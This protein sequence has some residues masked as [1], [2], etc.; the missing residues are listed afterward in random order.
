MK[1]FIDYFFKLFGI[2]GL[3]LGLS[4][5]GEPNQNPNEAPQAITVSVAP[6]LKKKITEWDE[7]TGRFQAVERVEV[8]ARVSGYISQ[9]NFEDGQV[10]QQGQTLY[11]IDPRPFQLSLERAKAELKR[12]LASKA[13]AESNFERV[14]ALK[15]SRAI[16]QEEYDQREQAL[17]A[18]NA[19]VQAA[20]AGVQSAELALSFTRVTAPITGRVS[21][22]LVNA[23]N[24]IRGG[25][26][27]GTL[28]TTIVSLDPIYFYFEGSEA[29]LLRYSRLDLRGER[30][31]SR[32]APNPVLVKLL[33]EK[34]YIHKG[35]MDFVDNELDAGTGTIEGRAVF[36]NPDNLLEPGMFGRARLL[37]REAQETMLVPDNIIVT[38]QSQKF[39]Y[40]LKEG[41][42]VK[43]QNVELGSLY[44]N[45]L[46]IVRK[47]LIEG[48]VVILN[49]I[50]KVRP[51][52]KINPKQTIIQ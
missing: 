21:R 29:D 11:V 13:Q 8:R 52:M 33:D 50:Q 22:D 20:Q 4:Q 34:D 2:V 30:K 6:P 9:V 24:L 35:Y 12:A 28:L 44:E 38:N 19:G 48:D 1:I 36:N 17:N 7:Y 23:G 45:D 47:G 31:A 42:T 5:C 37:S 32:K 43:V 40:T 18:A 51:G 25:D 15:D 46:R 10:I 14:R 49:N 27:G 41:D 3:L 39:V 16:S 26:S